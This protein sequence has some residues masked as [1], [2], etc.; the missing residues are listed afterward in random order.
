MAS[1]APADDVLVGGLSEQGRAQMTEGR[2]Y[3]AEELDL[4]LPDSKVQELMLIG[5]IGKEQR[6]DLEKFIKNC[7]RHKYLVRDDFEKTLTREQKIEALVKVY[8]HGYAFSKGLRGFVM[9]ELI[10]YESH[11][12]LNSTNDKEELARVDTIYKRLRQPTGDIRYALNIIRKRIH[13]HTMRDETTSERHRKY[14]KAHPEYDGIDTYILA[15]WVMT[16]GRPLVLSDPLLNFTSTFYGAIGI[17]GCSKRNVRLRL[18][19]VTRRLKYPLRRGRPRLKNGN[20][21]QS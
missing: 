9:K 12:V 7:L 5:Q 21:E 14:N 8:E 2:F 1:T 4:T 13:F 10:D 17:P 15:F 3:S 11:L 18:S 6:S 16:L 19:N 20:S